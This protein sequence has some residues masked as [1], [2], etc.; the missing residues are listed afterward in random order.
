MGRAER[1]RRM[2]QLRVAVPSGWV[3]EV[4][5]EELVGLDHEHSRRLV[6]APRP[7][8][9]PVVEDQCPRGAARKEP[10]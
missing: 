10:C 9:Q 1:P 4:V 2:T 5:L 8:V 3:A 7:D 6:D